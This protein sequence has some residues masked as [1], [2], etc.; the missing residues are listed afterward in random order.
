MMYTP[1]QKGRAKIRK[2]DQD[3]ARPRAHLRLQLR[4]HKTV[5]KS[6]ER[7]RSAGLFHQLDKAADKNHQDDHARIVG[8]RQLHKEI[9]SNHGFYR[10][11][12][13]AHAEDHRPHKSSAEQ[14]QYHVPAPDRHH[15]RN[16]RR[17]KAQPS[18]VHNMFLLPYVCLLDC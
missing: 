7:L 11:K 18:I 13:V 9:V 6:A 17:Q 4:V 10:Q 12:R 1:H 16:H 3:T 5:D 15:H 2:E 8:V 14:G